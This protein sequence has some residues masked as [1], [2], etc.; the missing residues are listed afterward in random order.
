MAT[1]FKLY[2]L[3]MLK[4]KSNKIVLPLGLYKQQNN[5]SSTFTIYR[6]E[7]IQKKK[8]LRDHYCEIQDTH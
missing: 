2:E 8:Y 7:G 1:Y 3:P 6:I 4:W 5:S